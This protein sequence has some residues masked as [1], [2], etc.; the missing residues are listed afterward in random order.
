[1]I[2]YGV[3]VKT[4][5]GGMTLEEA[6]ARAKEINESKVACAEVISYDDKDECDEDG[7]PLLKG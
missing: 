3:E 7:N 2:H 1:M 6:E 4:F 5:E